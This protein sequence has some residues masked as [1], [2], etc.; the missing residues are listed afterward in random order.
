MAEEHAK[1]K[2]IQRALTGE[3]EEVNIKAVVKDD[4]RRKVSDDQRKMDSF[5]HV[6]ETWAVATESER[7]TQEMEG[8]SKGKDQ[9][10]VRNKEAEQSSEREDDGHVGHVDPKDVITTPIEEDNGC[11]AHEIEEATSK[12]DIKEVVMDDTAK[13]IDERHMEYFV[14]VPETWVV[15]TGPRAIFVVVVELYYACSC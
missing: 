3:L 2:M 10:G 12:E 7:E 6:P 15:A 9:D 8:D 4:I 13:A 11:E 5:T 1:I 14:L